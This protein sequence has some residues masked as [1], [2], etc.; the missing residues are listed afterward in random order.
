[1]SPHIIKK[2]RLSLG[3]SQLKFATY[4]KCSPT[5]INRLEQGYH[6]VSDLVMQRISQK[7]KESKFQE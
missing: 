5:T 1:M 7:M 6:E 3:L 4:V 2:F